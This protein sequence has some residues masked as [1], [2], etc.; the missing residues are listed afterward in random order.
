MEPFMSAGSP[1]VSVV[2]PMY[3]TAAY[4]EEAVRSILNQTLTDLELIILDDE[5]TDHSVAVVSAIDDPRISVV[6]LPHG[7]DGP[8]RDAGI[9]LA[10]GHFVVWQ[11]SDDVAL[12]QRLERMVGAMLP[13]V[14]FV[15]HDMLFIDPS[16]RE[17]GYQRAS[18]ISPEHVLPYM[19]RTGCPFNCGT[20]M[21]RKSSIG[22]ALHTRDRINNDV[23]FMRQ[24]APTANGVHLPEP[25]YLYRKHATSTL[26]TMKST[27]E[28]PVLK[29]L[30]EQE[31]L[32][33]LVPDAFA[34][35]WDASDATVVALAFVALNF[36]R[37]G[38]PEQALALLEGAT[39]RAAG[40]EAATVI[41][42][43]LHLAVGEVGPAVEKLASLRVTA[44]TANLM[45]DAFGLAGDLSSATR[46]YRAA[47]TLNPR[48][49][50]AISG[51]RAT[52]Q[53][54]QL[55]VLDDP[56]RRLLGAGSR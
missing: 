46:A 7:G 13:G 49:F 33:A 48:S 37:R 1:L 17:F 45:G 8:A 11:D 30:L 50:D 16:G 41:A 20:V 27:D 15:H 29:R 44:F 34:V 14:D 25:L 6:S 10:R 5:S 38:F 22:S 54:G 53:A 35:G 36:W 56:G 31:P 39:H 4:V 18:N 26:A 9:H 23:D 3:N 40:T 2:M 19:L 21:W 55:W 32:E 28:L 12:P 47:L 52:G 24:L 43:I 51:L 42:G